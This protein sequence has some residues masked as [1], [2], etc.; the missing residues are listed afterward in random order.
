MGPG[1]DQAAAGPDITSESQS[2]PGA[3]VAGK[4]LDFSA[5]LDS[6]SLPHPTSFIPLCV[7][8]LLT[9]VSSPGSS[10]QPQCCRVGSLS[11]TSLSK[12]CGWAQ[13]GRWSHRPC[14]LGLIH[15]DNSHT[16]EDFY[17]EVSLSFSW[18]IIVSDLYGLVGRSNSRMRLILI[19]I[20][21]TPVEFGKLLTVQSFITHNSQICF[22]KLGNPENA[23]RELGHR[24]QSINAFSLIL[25]VIPIQFTFIYILHLFSC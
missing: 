6:W 23:H 7:T 24:R 1:P 22:V 11:F 17:W 9:P 25:K 21:A 4:W 8:D 13:V 14:S 20:Q 16:T 5:C 3:L 2:P 12:L 19:Q 10:L 18:I 15:C